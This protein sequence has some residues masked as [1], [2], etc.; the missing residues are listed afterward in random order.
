M[1]GGEFIHSEVKDVKPQ[2][3]ESY[4]NIKPEKEI[5]PK[6]LKEAVNGEVIKARNEVE[7]RENGPKE[8]R[9]DNGVKYR[10]GDTLLP[11]KVFEINKYT[12]KTDAYS[13]VISAEG[14]LQIKDHEGRRELDPRSAVDKGDMKDTDDRGH[15]IADRFNGSGGI[16]NLVPMDSHLNKH[17]DYAKMENTLADAMKAGCK[18][19]L[20]VEPRYAN[21]QTRPCELKVT[22][23][24]DGEKEVTVFKNESE[25]KS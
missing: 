8:Y 18:V 10:E 25:A 11:N 12:Y 7:S 3:A 6:E 2:S 22:Y 17:G 15:L 16:E 21:D 13:R 4:R 23:S 19:E 5:S 14:K 1:T 24:I 9:D 20:K